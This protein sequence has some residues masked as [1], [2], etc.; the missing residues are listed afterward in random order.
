MSLGATKWFES[1]SQ[2][3]VE[4][5]FFAWSKQILDLWESSLVQPRSLA[6]CSQHVQLKFL[7]VY[8]ETRE[9]HAFLN[10]LSG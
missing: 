9:S 6:H 7:S 2:D 5:G 3:A 8:L 10:E 4:L 1:S